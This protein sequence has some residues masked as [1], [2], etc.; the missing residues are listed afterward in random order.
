MALGIQVSFS[1]GITVQCFFWG[2]VSWRAYCTGI[3]YAFFPLGQAQV[4]LVFPLRRWS[5]VDIQTNVPRRFEG[6][7]LQNALLVI[8]WEPVRGGRVLPCLALC[9]FAVIF[10]YIQAAKTDKNDT[11]HFRHIAFHFLTQVNSRVPHWH[12]YSNLCH[13][14]GYVFVSSRGNLSRMGLTGYILS[15][16][17]FVTV[18]FVSTS[19]GFWCSSRCL[20]RLS[21]HFCWKRTDCF[22]GTWS[23]AS[24]H[25]RMQFIWTSLLDPVKT[26][27]FSLITHLKHQNLVFLKIFWTSFV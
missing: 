23:R 8:L 4:V 21:Y 24:I 7:R 27:I 26:S 6:T 19:H 1:N 15:F 20:C 10:L 3:F 18:E 9:V 2:G 5:F 17:F 12:D 13:F 25:G 11:L 22:C 16:F 14:Y